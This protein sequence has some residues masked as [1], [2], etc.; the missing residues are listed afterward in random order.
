MKVLQL[1]RLRSSRQTDFHSFSLTYHSRVNS[2]KLN[3]SLLDFKFKIGNF[4]LWVVKQKIFCLFYLPLF[5]LYG[6]LP[7]SLFTLL[8][9]YK[10]KWGLKFPLCQ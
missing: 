6:A 5:E 9:K 10:P 1:R 3:Y 4:P 7:G 2:T 8:E